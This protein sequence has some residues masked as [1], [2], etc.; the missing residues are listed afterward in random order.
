MQASG[1]SSL[2]DETPKLGCAFELGFHGVGQ[3]QDG[4]EMGHERQQVVVVANMQE[5]YM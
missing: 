4:L 3:V 5:G 2:L 1:F